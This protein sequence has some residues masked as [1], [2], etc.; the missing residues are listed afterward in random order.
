MPRAEFTSAVQRFSTSSVIA[1]Q[2]LGTSDEFPSAALKKPADTTR[3]VLDRARELL[4]ELEEWVILKSQELDE[5]EGENLVRVRAEAHS[6]MYAIR[7][8]LR[9]LPELAEDG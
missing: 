4:Q 5:F 1:Q 6:G 8:L 7:E 9:C 3:P 2:L